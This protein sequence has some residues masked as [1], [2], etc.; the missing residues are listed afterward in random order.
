M[1]E[2]P[3]HKIR[4]KST[5]KKKSVPKQVTNSPVKKQAVASPELQSEEELD[6]GKRRTVTSWGRVTIGADEW[7]R[8]MEFVQ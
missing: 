1:R 2:Q 7:I 3:D 6:I 5:V 8:V 4:H